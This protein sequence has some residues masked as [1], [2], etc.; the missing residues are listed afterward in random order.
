MTTFGYYI[1]VTRNRSLL[2][3][4]WVSSQYHLCLQRK[5]WHKYPYNVLI[6]EYS[7]VLLAVYV[8]SLSMIDSIDLKLK[9]IEMRQMH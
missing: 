3:V 2:L 1:G 8:C 6:T 7:L 9:E 4:K 5:V